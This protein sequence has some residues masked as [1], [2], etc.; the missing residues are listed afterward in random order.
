MERPRETQEENLDDLPPEVLEVLQS[1]DEDLDFL[2][3]PLGIAVP[4]EEKFDKGE[5]SDTPKEES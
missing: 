3:D 1:D 5:K 4:W 2:D